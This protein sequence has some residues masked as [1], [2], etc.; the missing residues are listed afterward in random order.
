MTTPLRLDALHFEAPG[1]GSWEAESA[2]LPRPCPRI[3]Q[4]IVPPRFARAFSAMTLRYGGLLSHLQYAFVNE[5]PYLQQVP[6]PAEEIPTRFAN[7]ERALGERLWRQDLARWDAEV[8]PAAIRRHLELQ[9]VDLEALGDE[10][11]L[12]HLDECI[13]HSG[14]MVEQHHHFNA[15]TILPTG[16]FL[17][18]VGKWADL[19][20]SQLLGCLRGSAPVSAGWSPELE[21]LADALLDNDAA[22][23]SLDATAPAR[24]L[25]E[26]LRHWPG[27]VG[28]AA[29]DYLAHH[30]WRI[31]DGFTAGDP[32]AIEVPEVLVTAIRSA[33]AADGPADAQGDADQTAELVRSLL[34]DDRRAEF[35]DLLAEARLTYR[36][37]D[38]RGIYSDVWAAGILRRAMLEAG[39]R[40]AER[41][42]VAE[43]VHAVE[44]GAAELV[45]LVRGTGGPSA[46]D[47]AE[48][49]RFRA[50]ARTIDAPQELGPPPPPP[51]PMDELP[52]AVRRVNEAIVT[53]MAHLFGNV[54]A[55]A[56][57]SR[58]AVRGIGASPGIVEGRARV[59]A[60]PDEIALLERG[61]VLVTTSTSEAFNQVLPLL[62]GIVT[63]SGGLLSHAAIVAR[64]FGIPCVVGCRVATRE[65]PDGAVVR[66]DGDG[67]E[68]R[69]L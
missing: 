31:A 66:I 17:N 54:E 15:A 39:R 5:I 13:E 10:E 46:E 20:P 41:G 53:V 44:A 3:F 45:A 8:K 19:S 62:A 60:G 21:A 33:V 65:L 25:I 64:E 59:L 68:V 58:Q 48:R 40:L 30:E 69:I 26:T 38:E 32:C 9:G 57:S 12:D 14:A 27:A 63:D 37:R 51:P 4:E 49:A 2:H 23:G 11:L 56:A 42:R 24:E 61:D 36:L 22:R 43:P 52:P 55:S 7:A 18:Q 16:D 6:A 29:R 35:D 34:A 28:A 67:G 1:P 50:W 47:L